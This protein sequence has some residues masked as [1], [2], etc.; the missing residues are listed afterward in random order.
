[1]KKDFFDLFALSAAERKGVIVLVA[2]ILVLSAVQLFLAFRRSPPAS[3]S[4][5]TFFHALIPGESEETEIAELYNPQSGQS[6]D[7]FELFE[8]DPNRIDAGDLI[9]LG[10]H[11]KV[12]RTW[13]NYRLHGGRFYKPED[14]SKIYGLSR[15][16]ADRLIPFVK[17]ESDRA[18]RMEA[19][20][21]KTV[22]TPAKKEI[23]AGDSVDFLNIPGIGPVLS[24]R[25]TRY[26]S[27][28]GGYYGIEQLKEVYGLHDSLIPYVAERFYA[29]TSRIEKINVNE[30]TEDRIRR[31]PYIGR[32]ISRGIIA[33]RKQAGRIKSIDELVT[34]G[35]LSRE[36]FEKVRVYLV[37]D[38]GY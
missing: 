31:H 37:L 33:Y 34:N 1:M 24:G 17:I 10:I 13:L 19:S 29:D 2:I 18:G 26:R 15:E 30:A 3:F 8:F 38:G 9:R 22:R 36:E 23:N 16:T 35:I 12:I 20:F 6:A 5:S 4:D 27:L 11:E 14:I 7:T 25:I 21:Y 32:H 28:L